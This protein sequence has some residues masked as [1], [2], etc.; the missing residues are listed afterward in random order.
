MDVEFVDVLCIN[1]Y[2]CIRFNDV[3]THS[4]ECNQNPENIKGEMATEGEVGGV[5]NKINM[6]NA[7]GDNRKTGREVNPARQPVNGIG[8]DRC[9]F[10]LIKSIKQRLID[11]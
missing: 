5:A 6:I 4:L 2:E 10:M 3:D 7:L 1:C 11:M 8:N 9:L